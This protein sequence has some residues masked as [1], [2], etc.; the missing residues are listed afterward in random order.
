[1]D[2]KQLLK[3]NWLHRKLHNDSSSVKK[4]PVVFQANFF[5]SLAN[6]LS[7][8]F[9]LT[10]ALKFIA[11]TD[12]QLSRGVNVVIGSLKAGREFSESVR[13]LIETQA[14]HQLLI[15]E[16]HGQLSDILNELANFDRLRLKQLK[17]IKAMLVYPLF[18]CLILGT[19]ILMIRVYVLP[20]IQDL[21]PTA[22]HQQ[23]VT[24]WQQ[25]I[26]LSPIPILIGIIGSTVHWSRQDAI[27]QAQMIV[28]IPGV[29]K[30][31]RKYIAYYLASNL[32]TLLKNGLSVKEIYA[33]LSEFKEGSLIHLLGER[34]HATL[35]SGGSL[36]K[37]VDRHNFIPNEIIKFMSSG[38]TI[39]EMAN[40]MTAYSR[41]MFDEMILT[42]DKLI[43]FIQPAMFVVIGVT[44]ISTYFQLLI[45][46]YNSV[47]GMY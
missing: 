5:D 15:A 45:P 28:K 11:D 14:Y 37:L 46:I 47:K 27:T 19:L 18:L 12:K 24:Y 7:I 2:S 22:N 17:K 40:S 38:N 31:F 26:R 10:Q 20:Q 6:L 43:G 32:A 33:T 1:M 29:G 8:G 13:P 16:K 41:L 35:L 23:P 36:R 34:L 3:Q 44:I 42:T 21:M 30:L 9:S 25:L 39:P 4:W